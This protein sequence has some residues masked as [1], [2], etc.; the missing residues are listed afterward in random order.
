AT[1]A[2]VRL[3]NPVLGN[4]ISVGALAATGVLPLTRGDL[5]AVLSRRMSADK[6]ELNLTA[7]DMGAAMIRG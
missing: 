7:F 2:A 5:E 1:E 3:G 6:V 4:I